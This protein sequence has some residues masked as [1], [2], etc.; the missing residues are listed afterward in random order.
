[1]S[2]LQ[3]AVAQVDKLDELLLTLSADDN[4]VCIEGQPGSL[5]YQVNFTTNFEDRNGF[6]TGIAKYTEQAAVHA[7]LVRDC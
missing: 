3:E 2:S 7:A 5:Q 1:M 4:Q 6:V